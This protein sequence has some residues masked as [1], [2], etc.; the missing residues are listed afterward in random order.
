MNNEQ[1]HIALRRKTSPLNINEAI[2]IIEKKIEWCESVI[3]SEDWEN[4][5]MKRFAK[6]HAGIEATTLKESLEIFK[7]V[8]K[9]PH[10]Q[11]NRECNTEWH[12]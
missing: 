3:K 6:N 9:Y 12:Y 7:R 10:D 8:K 2:E 11:F 4:E 5:E 1:V